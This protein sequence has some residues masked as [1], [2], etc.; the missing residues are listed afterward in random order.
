MSKIWRNASIHIVLWII[1]AG[2]LFPIWVMFSTSLQSYENIFNWPPEWFPDN[3]Q[4]SNY[5]TVWFGDYQFK[6]P[7]VNSL[8]VAS[9]TALITILLSFPASY[10]LSRFT[11]VGRNSILFIVLVTQ[12]FSP[13]VLIVGLY[14]MAQTYNLLNTFTGLIITNCALTLPMAV[15]LLHGYLKSIPE[16]IEYAAFVDGC[17]RISGIFRIVMPLSAPGIA[18]V[19]IY[20]FIMAWN[21]LLIP[22]I[23]ISKPEMRPVSLALTDFV[24]QNIVYWHEM[25]AASV[26]TTVP[27]AVM[28]SFVQKYFIKGFMSGAVKE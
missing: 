1:F 3:P 16:S 5:I 18:M 4:W 13:L 26:L 15:W 2:M 7:F 11:F 10:A 27:I 23:F 9:M 12:M 6:T 20:S 19:A 28:F 17:S 14:K 22:L 21:D 25:M 24:G 8:I